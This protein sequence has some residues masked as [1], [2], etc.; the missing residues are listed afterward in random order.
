MAHG[1]RCIGPGPSLPL[2]KWPMGTIL[3]AQVQVYHCRNGPWA[4]IYWPRSKFTTM[5]M[6]HGP[7]CIVPGPS[8]PLWQWPMGTILLAQVQVYQLAQVQS[9][10][11]WIWPMGQDLTTVEMAHGRIFIVPGPNLPLWKWPMGRDLFGPGPILPLWK[12]PMGTISI[13]LVHGHHSRNDPWAI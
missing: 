2:W 5:E 4:E 8:L 7:R 13:A 10:P 11:L 1:L 6:A 9:L 12:W 3:L